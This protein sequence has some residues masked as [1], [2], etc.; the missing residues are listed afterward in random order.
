MTRG[1]AR[2]VAPARRERPRRGYDRQ[3]SADTLRAGVR[4]RTASDLRPL[5]FAYAGRICVVH[6]R[7]VVELAQHGGVVLERRRLTLPRSY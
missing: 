4:T 5:A 7:G 1:P 3:I 2:P 6:E